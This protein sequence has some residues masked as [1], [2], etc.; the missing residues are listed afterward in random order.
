[1]KPVIPSVGSEAALY[2]EGGATTT[3]QLTIV[4]E[5]SSSNTHSK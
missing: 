2:Y 1:M 5:L 4:N 3:A